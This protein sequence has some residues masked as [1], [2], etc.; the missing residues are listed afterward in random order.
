M[1]ASLKATLAHAFSLAPE[2]LAPEDEAFLS[3]I[4]ARI[5]A[6]KLTAPALLAVDGIRYTPG[7]SPTLFAM[8]P[9]AEVIAPFFSLGVLQGP[10]EVRRLVRIAE[11]REHLDVLSKKIEALS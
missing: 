9:L 5:A 2:P 1:L 4:A 3:E 6:R 10:D 7:L 8:G 11:R